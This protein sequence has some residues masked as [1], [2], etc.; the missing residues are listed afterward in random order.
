MNYFITNDFTADL[1]SKSRVALVSLL[2]RGFQRDILERSNFSQLLTN[3]MENC[4]CKVCAP[5]RMIQA[6]AELIRYHVKSKV[7]FLRPE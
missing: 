7:I 5:S 3:C 6:K 4:A 2:L 1:R